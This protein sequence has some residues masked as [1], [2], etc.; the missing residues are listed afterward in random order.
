MESNQDGKNV[1]NIEDYEMIISKKDDEIKKL[2]S[3]L[4]KQN[5]ILSRTKSYFFDLENNLNIATNKVDSLEA[6]LE[7]NK[8]NFHSKEEF[9]KNQKKALEIIKSEY[10]TQLSQL[11]SKDYCIACYKEKIKDNDTEINYFSPHFLI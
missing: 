2:N 4:S 11:D 5:L 10:Y 3:E 1:K 7:K 9:F 8:D 6:E